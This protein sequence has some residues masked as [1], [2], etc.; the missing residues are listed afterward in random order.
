[1]L[2]DYCLILKKCVNNVGQM[3]KEN[4]FFSFFF[5]FFFITFA[6]ING[7]NVLR[8]NSQVVCF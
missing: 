1:M 7:K 6:K 3:K 2:F 4:S 8:K 5:F